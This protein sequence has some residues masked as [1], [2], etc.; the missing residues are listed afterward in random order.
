MPNF[1]PPRHGGPPRFGGGFGGPGPG[2]FMPM[3]PNQGP[4]PPRG[5]GGP[6]F[7]GPF[8]DKNFRPPMNQGPPPRMMGPDFDINGPG[9]GV[10][11]VF[12]SIGLVIFV[13]KMIS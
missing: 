9:P 4:P 1:G 11:R 6:P 5:M 10:S 8:P 3:H 7:P 13:Y 12:D 2:N